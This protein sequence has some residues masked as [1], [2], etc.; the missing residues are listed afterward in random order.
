MFLNKVLRKKEIKKLTQDM[1]NNRYSK[2][3]IKTSIKA[4]ILDVCD[5]IKAEISPAN[6]LDD[7]AVHQIQN[8][9]DVYP[10]I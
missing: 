5:K 9:L 6:F 2:E 10:D 7:R 3:E 1:K 4:N 8:F